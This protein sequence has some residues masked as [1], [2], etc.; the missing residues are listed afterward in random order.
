VKANATDEEV[1]SKITEISKGAIKQTYKILLMRIDKF[2][3]AQPNI[4]L[5]ENKGIINVEL[6]G[7]DNVE[8]VE[9]LLQASAHLQFWEVYRIDELANSLKL[10]DD[11]LHK[12]LNGDTSKVADSNSIKKN[13]NPFF[14][15]INP[16]DVQT[17]KSGKQ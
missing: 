16:I 1:V 6:A 2:G 3:V 8:R 7:V 13:A 15:V 10:A 11:N 17:D 9:K 14:R 12:Y 5:D 4:N